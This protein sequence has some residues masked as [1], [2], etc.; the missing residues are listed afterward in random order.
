MFG[1]AAAECKFETRW[2][3]SGSID[4]KDSSKVYVLA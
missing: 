1:T 4:L 2:F 3:W